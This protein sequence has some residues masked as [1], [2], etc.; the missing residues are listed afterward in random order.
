MRFTFQ[1]MLEEA[2]IKAAAQLMASNDPWVTLGRTYEKCLATIRNP[3]AEAYV[4][5]VDDVV[6]GLAIIQLKGALV[7]YIQTLLIAEQYRGH[8][9]GNQMI[10]YLENRIYEFSPN[11]FMCV[12]DFNK[13]A[14]RLYARMGYEVIG[15]I[16]NY[17]AEGHSEILLRKTIAAMN[18]FK[19]KR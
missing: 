2:D 5:K 1:P 7:G 18:D 17:I 10:T 13:D 12:S 8:T 15:E 4:A 6:M 19:P 3:L 11:I 16:K 14:Q 9:L